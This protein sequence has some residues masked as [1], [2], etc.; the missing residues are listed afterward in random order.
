[1]LELEARVS[2]N[3][4][5]FAGRTLHCSVRLCNRDDKAHTLAWASAQVHC[6]SSFNRAR[7]AL[8]SAAN[9]A[10]N[11]QHHHHHQQ[12]TAFAFTPTKGKREGEGKREEE[13]EGE[14]VR[15]GESV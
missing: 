8:S 14:E 12:H 10:K 7:V 4:V 6:Q 15:R 1:M 5:I 3:P 9:A 13:I 2:G 11:E